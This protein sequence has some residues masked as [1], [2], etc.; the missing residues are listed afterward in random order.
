MTTTTPTKGAGTTFWRLKDTA[1]LSQIS[2]F[3]ADDQ[4]DYIAKVKE[5]QPGEI[6]VED[7]DDQYLD[8]AEADWSKTA[9]GQKT[10]GDLSLTLAWM[11]GDPAQQ[12]LYKD[13]ETGKV[14][15]YRTKFPNGTVDI[16]YGYINGWGKAVAQKERM[17]RT[18][19]IK[20]VGKPM[21]AEEI[22]A[23]SVGPGA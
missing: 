11:P 8:D 4:W 5:I 16:D 3:L 15:H 18:I 23:D 17:T 19:K 21:T 13:L 20:K 22:I 1:T 10:A 14:T 7:E 12:Q 2:D 9:P 6:T